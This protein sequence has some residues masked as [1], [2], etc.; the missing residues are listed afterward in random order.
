MILAF[1]LGPLLEENLQRALVLSNGD[2]TTFLTN[3]ISALFLAIALA[4]VGPYHLSIAEARA[5]GSLAGHRPVTEWT[6]Q[7][8]RPTSWGR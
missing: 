5:G 2:A 7:A 6:P 4:L 1:V 8:C 3:P